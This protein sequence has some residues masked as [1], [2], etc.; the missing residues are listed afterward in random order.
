MEMVTKE[1]E[2]RMYQSE[3]PNSII[4]GCDD[5]QYLNEYIGKCIEIIN[6][7][8]KMNITPTT[9]IYFMSVDPH[10]MELYRIY[11]IINNNIYDTEHIDKHIKE[12]PW[13]DSVVDDLSLVLYNESDLLRSIDILS[14][15]TPD[16]IFKYYKKYPLY[17]HKQ[18]VR[19]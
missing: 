12:Y 17:F 3:D 5:I 13:C 8:D 1:I 14:P 10:M 11:N 7:S 4:I 19:R 9:N 6:K 15:K 16:F 18:M 2:F